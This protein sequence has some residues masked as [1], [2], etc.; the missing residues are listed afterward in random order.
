[1]FQIDDSKAH[2]Q[3]RTHID[4]ADM[5]GAPLVS[6]PATADSAHTITIPFLLKRCKWR[7]NTSVDEAW[8]VGVESD[9]G[10]LREARCKGLAQR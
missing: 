6:K 9:A 2:A 5:A 4:I 8:M 10:R 3:E 7:E 1:M